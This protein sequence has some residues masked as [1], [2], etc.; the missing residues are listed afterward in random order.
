M[1]SVQHLN[2]RENDILAAI[3]KKVASRMGKKR[4]SHTLGVKQEILR[5]GSL[6]LPDQLFPLALSALL[7]DITKEWSAEEQLNFCDKREILLTEEER[8]VP[9]TLHSLTGAVLSRELFSDLVTPEIYEAIRLHTT[10]GRDMTVFDKLLYLSDYIEEGRTHEDCLA[11]RRRFWNGYSEAPDKLRHL[12]QVV[13]D[14]FCMTR[15]D[16]LHRGGRLLSATENAIAFLKEELD[17]PPND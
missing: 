9:Y 4:F 6:Y 16:V 17:S 10:G 5:L 8:A 11:L 13:L 2:S 1:A 7:H 15:E 3:T 14:A 12:N